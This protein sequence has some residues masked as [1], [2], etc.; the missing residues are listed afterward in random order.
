MKVPVCTRC[1]RWSA[2]LSSAISFALLQTSL[3]AQGCAPL[4]SPTPGAN[5]PNDTV[6]AATAWDPDGSGPSQPLLVVGGRFTA[7][8]GAPA[9]RLASFDFGTGTWA[10]FGGFDDTVLAVAASPSGELIVAGR[11]QS[12][13]G[14]PIAS[15]ARWNG[16]AWSALPGLAGILGAPPDIRDMAVGPQG[17]VVVIG[18]FLIGGQVATVGRWNGSSWT[19]LRG[20]GYDHSAVAVRNNGNVVVATYPFGALPPSDAAVFESSGTA[21]AQLGGTFGPATIAALAEDAAGELLAGGEFTTLWGAPGD[22][23]AR[24]T[25]ASWQAVGQGLRLDV[26]SLVQLPNAD[27]VAVGTESV[28]TFPAGELAVRWNG[29]AWAPQGFGTAPSNTQGIFDAQWMADGR[30]I[31]VGSFANAGPTVVSNVGALVAPC[32]ATAVSTAPGCVGAGGLNTLAALT[33]PWLGS[34]Y[35]YRGDGLPAIALGLN[36][37]GLLGS[38]IPLANILPQGLPSCSLAASPDLLQLLVPTAGAVAGELVVPSQVS[39]IGFVLQQQLIA[40]D[41]AGG[42]ITAVTSSNRLTLTLGVF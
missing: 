6:L 5:G 24:W 22:K 26:R 42:A 27:V 33:G 11:F 10:P 8:A 28:V 21:F 41:L 34:S 4:W 17:E 2:S 19:S 20:D 18:A 30:L 15:I 31:V 38:N 39:L 23:V 32:V 9:A 35:R 13:L 25:G 16:V 36:V 12:V 40:L 29:S 37:F 14:Q 7:V 3:L 1:W